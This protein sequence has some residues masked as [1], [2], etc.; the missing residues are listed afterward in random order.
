VVEID[1]S[2]RTV[3]SY[4]TF[5]YASDAVR[6]ANGNMVIVSRRSNRL[7]EHDVQG[8]PVRELNVASPR[9]LQLLPS[10]NIIVMSSR[11][12]VEYNPGWTEVAKGRIPQYPRANAWRIGKNTYIAQDSTLMR[13][14]HEHKVIKR[15]TLPAHADSVF[16]Y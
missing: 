15:V 9:S 10:G 11:G 3:T 1:R 5:F 16:A 8:K 7:I 2:G 14:D 6:R 13:L 12:A 4:P